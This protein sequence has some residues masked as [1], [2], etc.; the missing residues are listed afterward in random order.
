MSACQSRTRRDV[1]RARCVSRSRVVV[2]RPM[3]AVTYFLG[4]EHPQ[5]PEMLHYT[6]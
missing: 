3:V 6:S 4:A 1:I 5:H 2:L